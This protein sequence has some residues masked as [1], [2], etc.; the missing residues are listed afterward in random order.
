L[1][2]LVVEFV[3]EFVF[4]FVFVAELVFTVELT[5]TAELVLVLE[6]VLVVKFVSTTVELALAAPV[7][8]SK[9]T[10][11]DASVDV[12]ADC[13]CCSLFVS[14]GETLSAFWSWLGADVL[15]LSVF[16]DAMVVVAP[17]V[18]TLTTFIAAAPAVIVDAPTKRP[19]SNLANSCLM[20]SNTAKRGSLLQPSPKSPDRRIKTG[21]SDTMR[22]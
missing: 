3:M 8:S 10:S 17:A 13:S 2:T 9:E 18:F 20:L 6:F 15:V 21:F 19:A 1:F 4:V 14:F 7:L 5:S 11:A 12:S 16:S 22:R